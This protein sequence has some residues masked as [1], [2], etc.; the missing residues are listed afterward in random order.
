M[1]GNLST[2]LGKDVGVIQNFQHVVAS[3]ALEVNL[4]SKDV[5][6]PDWSLLKVVSISRLNDQTFVLCC[7]TKLVVP[8]G[9]VSTVGTNTEIVLAPKFF[10]N[11]GVDLIH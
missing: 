4:V 10:L 2:R 8:R 3:F 1:G 7:Y 9:I 5:V 6:S 11:L